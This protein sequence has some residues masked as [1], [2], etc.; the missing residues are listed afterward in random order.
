MKGYSYHIFDQFTL[1]TE[2]LFHLNVIVLCISSKKGT[3]ATHLTE[4][5]S[6]DDPLVDG[7]DGYTNH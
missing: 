3:Y 7:V 1:L 2:S 4:G 5:A 6:G